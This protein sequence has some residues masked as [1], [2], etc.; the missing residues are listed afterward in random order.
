[1]DSVDSRCRDSDDVPPL[2]RATLTESGVD[3]DVV[4]RRAHDIYSS[5][6]AGISRIGRLARTKELYSVV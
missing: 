1:M 4:S 5:T 2:Y 6:G 3:P